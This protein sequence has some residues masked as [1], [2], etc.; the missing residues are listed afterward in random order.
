MIYVGIDAAKDKHDCCIL[1][2]NGQTVQEAF[3]FRNNHEGFEQM[4]TEI[5]RCS[6]AEGSG[7]IRA[8]LES[9]GHYS[10]NLEAFLR[11]TGVELVVF[12]P[13]QVTQYRKSQT[14]R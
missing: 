8:G 13:L 4:R 12:N 10:G 1:G 7:Q 14:L 11:D 3:T 2:G 9:T 6:E 5:Q